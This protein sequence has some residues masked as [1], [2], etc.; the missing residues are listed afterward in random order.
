MNRTRSAATVPGSA[1]FAAPAPATERDLRVQSTRPSLGEAPFG[2][3]FRA[4]QH[5][6]RTR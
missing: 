4:R 3:S 5:E 2:C 1:M 6:A